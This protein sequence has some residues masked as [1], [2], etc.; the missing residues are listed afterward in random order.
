MGSIGGTEGAAWRGLS[1]AALAALC[2]K[3]AHEGVVLAGWDALAGA[4]GGGQ[5]VLQTGHAALAGGFH[6]VHHGEA[7]LDGGRQ[8]S[9]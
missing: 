9:E 8:V 3:K 4:A 7:G 5:A 1:G 2:P 6:L